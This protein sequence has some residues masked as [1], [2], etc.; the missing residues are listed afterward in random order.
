MSDLLLLDPVRRR[1]EGAAPVTDGRVRGA[2]VEAYLEVIAKNDQ[3]VVAGVTFG[4]ADSPG[5]APL[6]SA[7]A[8]VTREGASEPWRAGAALNLTLLPPG[9]YHAVAIVSD[10]GRVIGRVSRPIR[11]DRAGAAPAAAAAAPGSA[12]PR[13]DAGEPRVAFTAGEAGGLVKAFA[14]DSVLGRET[15]EYFLGRLRGV[16]SEAS[17]MPAL[18]PAAD[19]LLTAR[20]DDALVSL[21][22]VDAARFSVAFMKG[23]A[24]FGKGSLEPAAAQFRGSLDLSPDFLPAAFYLGACYAAGGQDREAVGAWQIALISDPHARIIYDVL[25]DALLRLQDGDQAAGLLAEAHDEWA[26]DDRFVPR[27][28]AAEALRGR[29][30]EALALLDGYIT[31][32]PTDTDVI[33]LGMRLLYETRTAGRHAR[34]ADEDALAAGRYA[35]LY[36]A[37]GGPNSGLVDRWAA[38][39]AK[40]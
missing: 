34:S 18:G 32:H 24:L 6:V 13:G 40:K 10:G 14:R 39:L 2:D 20:Y 21:A 9:G 31:R 35:E 19:A 3:A 25:G 23:L 15:L 22:A 26:D 16:E 17:I 4:V 1:E 11:I 38:Y 33:F 37:A 12:P 5:G 36:R 7:R 29:A 27:L 8:S 28:A 30:A